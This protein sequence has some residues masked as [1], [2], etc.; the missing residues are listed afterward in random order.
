MPEEKRLVGAAKLGDKSAFEELVRR[1]EKKIYNN[2]N[3]TFWNCEDTELYDVIA[4]SAD[5]IELPSEEF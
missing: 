3:L 1:Y 5:E 2:P 4:S